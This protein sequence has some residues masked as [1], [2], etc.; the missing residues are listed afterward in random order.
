MHDDHTKG[1]LLTTRTQ[2]Q[3]YEEVRCYLRRKRQDATGTTITQRRVIMSPL[4]RAAIR[5]DCL[6]IAVFC[7][8][9]LC[10]CI[11]TIH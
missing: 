4:D 7:S 2:N 1:V 6:I 10:L 5:N 9:I 11:F 8:R 3:N